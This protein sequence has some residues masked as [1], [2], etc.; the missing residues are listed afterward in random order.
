[1][2]LALATGAFSGY[3]IWRYRGAA[4]VDPVAVIV[5]QMKTHSVIEHQR[6]VSVWYRACPTVWGRSPQIF[7]AWPAQLTYQVELS[8]IKV[9]RDGGVIHVRTS[10]IHAVDPI[11]PTDRMAYM[12][13]TSMLTFANE[14]QLINEEIAK[15]T[16]VARYLSAYFLAHDPSL[17][18]DFHDEL[19]SLVEHFT[20]SLGVPITQVDVDITQVEASTYPALPKIELCAGTTAAVNGLPFAKLDLGSTRPVGFTL[21]PRRTPDALPDLVPPAAPPPRQAP[22]GTAGAAPVQ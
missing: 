15:S 7:M 18:Q 4:N 1:M 13:A 21:Q 3:E 11:V 2:L 5:T 17:V 10:P 6:Q 16:P 20:A 9:S 19:Q 12:A 22:T 14:Q 8:D